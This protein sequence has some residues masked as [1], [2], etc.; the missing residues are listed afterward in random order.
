MSLLSGNSELLFFLVP[1]FLVLY[2]LPAILAFVLNRKH[3][4][5]ILIANVPAGLSWVMWL[6]ILAWAFTGKE[7]STAA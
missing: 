3:K 4:M 6:A 1:A 7:K 2:F 5:Q